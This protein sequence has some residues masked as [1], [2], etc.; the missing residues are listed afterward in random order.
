MKKIIGIIISIILIITSIS[1][2]ALITDPILIQTD[3][4][5]N[6]NLNYYTFRNNHITDSCISPNNGY[7]T[8]DLPANCPYIAPID[9]MHIINGLPSGTTIELDPIIN[10]FINIVRIPGGPLGGEVLQYD[11]SLN[12]DIS[13]TGDLTGFTRNIIMP[14]SIEINTGPR[15]PGDIVQSFPSE[16]YRLTGNIY[17]D[18]DFCT[19][20]ITIGAD[21]GLPSPG[22]YILTRLP[23]GDYNIDS[24]FDIT[25]RIEFDGCPGSILEGMS[26][27]T[28][29][30]IRIQQGTEFINNQPN[31]PSQLIGP[32][33]GNIHDTL[34]YTSSSIDPDGD[35]IR[36]GIDF[37][38]D[39]TVDSW[40]DEYYPSG[41][42][43][44]FHITFNSVGTFQLSLKAEDIYGADSGWSTPKT[45]IIS[46]E[47][48]NPPNKP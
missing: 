47:S 39:G 13:G 11:A 23:T 4:F 12:L 19:F 45:V 5:T 17:G 44:N 6:E 8:I 2:S 40:S 9:P 22:Q 34:T 25:Y 14:V 15:N 1:A 27:T 16:I 32:P 7:G 37:N 35:N 28:I 20:G 43:I 36:Y 18:P 31:T 46:E 30:T 33:T 3:I 21:Y 29:D 24:F 38:N 48:N 41:A 42:I 10:N 26:G